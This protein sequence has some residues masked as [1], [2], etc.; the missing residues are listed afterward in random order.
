MIPLMLAIS[1]AL[2]ASV[3]AQERGDSVYRILF[4]NAENL[5]DTENDTI[6]DD[7]DFLPGGLMRWNF[8]RYS[9]KISSLYKVLIAS[10]DWEP[11]V[12]IGLCEIENRKV[13][14][15]LIYNTPLSQ[16]NYGIIHGESNDPRGIDVAIIYR[17][18][19]FDLVFSR[20]LIPK[21]YSHSRF[22]TRDV[23]YAKFFIS[24]DTVHL[25]LNHWPSRRG[26]VLAGEDERRNISRMIREMAD[27]INRSVY[28]KGK[29][30][31]AGDFNCTPDDTEIGIL[32]KHNENGDEALVLV[33]LAKGSSQ[34]GSGTYKY[35]G[36]WEMLDQVIVSESLLSSGPG[37]YTGHD[38]FRV[39]SPEFL[40]EKDP[41]YPGFKPFSTYSGYRYRGGF[42][43][44]LPVI[45]DLKFR[46]RGQ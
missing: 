3:T 33:N 20:L 45:L 21:E 2:S 29:I 41:A 46:K 37:I 18:D 26:G 32:M 19:I 34:M 12:I 15:K 27:S 36:T 10:G 14:E 13:L 35:R 23:L 43:D 11:P 24:E 1:F 28:G 6:K 38:M 22:R 39:F 40:L 9:G 25:F 17:R 30:I 4:Y 8:Y 42:S 5:F 7:D 16:F 31:V 44:H